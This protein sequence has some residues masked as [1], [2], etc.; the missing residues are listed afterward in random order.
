MRILDPSNCLAGRLVSILLILLL[1]APAPSTLAAVMSA[2]GLAS[3]DPPG[4]VT[5]KKEDKKKEE[6]KPSS[7]RMGFGFK[8]SDTFYQKGPAPTTDAAEHTHVKLSQ[9]EIAA[10]QKAVADFLQT[11]QGTLTK[12]DASFGARR[13]VLTLFT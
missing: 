3:D 7:S 9:S 1:L 12:Q 11:R 8:T 10:R 4:F 6:D 2:S 5:V 13:N